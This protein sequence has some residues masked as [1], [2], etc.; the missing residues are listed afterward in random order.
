M[1]EATRWAVRRGGGHEFNDRETDRVSQADRVREGQSK[2]DTDS[3]TDKERQSKTNRHSQR[4]I[5]DGR[6]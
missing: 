1:V 6:D 2:T 4:Q 5:E 3:Q